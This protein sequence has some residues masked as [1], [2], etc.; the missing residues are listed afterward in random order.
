MSSEVPLR[1]RLET[2]QRRLCGRMSVHVFA[3][4]LPPV[5]FD[6][7]YV[8]ATKSLRGNSWRVT[9]WIERRLPSG[10]VYY[11]RAHTRVRRSQEAA[12]KAANE[13][14]AF[15]SRSNPVFR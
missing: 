14:A 13:M 8:Q 2:K 4:L 15:W 9:A 7:G 12:L 1:R 3:V 11:S 5:P 6:C 10:M